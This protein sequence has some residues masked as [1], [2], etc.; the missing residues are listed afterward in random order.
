MPRSYGENRHII[1]FEHII[2]RMKETKCTYYHYG[3]IDED[4]TNQEEVA[5]MTKVQLNEVKSLKASPPPIVKRAM[6]PVWIVLHC[7]QFAKGEA[8]LV[9]LD[10]SKEW[11]KIQRMLISDDFVQVITSFDGSDL[12]SVPWVVDHV[13]SRYFADLLPRQGAVG[14]RP[15]TP[16]HPSSPSR[17][18]SKLGRSDSRTSLSGSPTS[19]FKAAGLAAVAGARLAQLP[20]Q[21]LELEAV[22]RASKA[23]G[24]LVKWVQQVIREFVVLRQLRA[25]HASA[26]SKARVTE[27]RAANC[28]DAAGAAQG[29]LGEVLAEMEAVARRLAELQ[30]EALHAEKAL[31]DLVLMGEEA[32]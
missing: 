16:S 28:R 4:A 5:A 30:A 23:C 14:G 18:G 13:A 17:A 20:Q 31:R 3:I 12:D 8:A 6:E 26:S 11:T 19:A 7:K 9:T 21:P 1:P 15:S 25:E 2:N 24:V 29:R 22:E 10:L 32:E 27:E